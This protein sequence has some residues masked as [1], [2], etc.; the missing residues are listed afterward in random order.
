MAKR[1]SESLAARFERYRR[2]I[3]APLADADLLAA[4]VPYTF[5]EAWFTQ[6][7]VL[8]QE[9]QALNRQKEIE[10]GEQKAA[11]RLFDEAHNRAYAAYSDAIQVARVAF[12]KDVQAQSSLGLRGRRKE[13]FSGRWDQAVRFYDNLLQQAALVAVMARYT[14]DEVKLAQEQG[15]WETA[16]N[17]KTNQDSER[18]QAQAATKARDAKFDE[19]DD[20]MADVL[21][22]APIA[23]KAYPQWLEKMGIVEPS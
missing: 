2:A 14:Y 6:T 3:E 20:R 13:S 1:R 23:L 11:T 7:R 22:L 12:K 8:L 16:V 4:L 10:Y 18:G 5:D 17:A 21:A 19:L 15:L 9:V